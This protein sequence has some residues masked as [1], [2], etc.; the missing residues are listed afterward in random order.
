VPVAVNCWVWPWAT[1]A[2]VGAT[3][4][5]ANVPEQANAAWDV[6]ASATPTTAVV[7]SSKGRT[8]VTTDLSQPRHILAPPLLRKLIR[9]R[10]DSPL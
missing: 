9:L 3:A 10:P 1:E 4:M 5:V 8:R 7:T 6:R 2:V